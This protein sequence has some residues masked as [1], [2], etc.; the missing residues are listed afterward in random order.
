VPV[1]AALEIG[2]RNPRALNGNARD[3]R[4]LGRKKGDEL[5]SPPYKRVWVS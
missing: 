4:L 2:V 3:F 1:S 5:S